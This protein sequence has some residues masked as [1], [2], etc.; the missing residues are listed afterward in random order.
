M[1]ILQTVKI[2]FYSK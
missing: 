1:R 2:S